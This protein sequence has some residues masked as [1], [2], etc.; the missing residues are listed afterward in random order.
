M[1]VKSL[2]EKMEHFLLSPLQ[3]EGEKTP[4]EKLA[5]GDGSSVSMLEDDKN[6]LL[7]KSYLISGDNSSQK[8][9]GDKSYRVIKVIKG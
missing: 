1:K 3:I 5:I 9:P 8:L 7:K 2:C 6:N 4:L